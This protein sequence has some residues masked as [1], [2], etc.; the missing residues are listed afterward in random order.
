ML[1]VLKKMYNV[2]FTVNGM[3]VDVLVKVADM[4][5]ISYI[6]YANN[7]LYGGTIWCLLSMIKKMIKKKMIMIKK[8]ENHIYLLKKTKHI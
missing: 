1:V 4:A 8:K 5:K 6:Q 2:Y 3:Q 7:Q